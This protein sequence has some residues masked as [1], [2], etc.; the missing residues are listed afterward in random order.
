MVAA[1]L[2]VL[3][4]ACGHQPWSARITKASIAGDD[5]TVT[6]TFEGERFTDGPVCT[7]VDRTEVTETSAV[8]TVEVFI[9]Y[10]C[11]EPGDPFR[12]TSAEQS[13]HIRLESLLG[14]RRLETPDRQSIA[15]TRP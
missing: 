1:L 10:S 6:V 12:G 9:N 14:E 11:V 2:G 13:T 3:I 15:I 7:E 4:T 5:Q 8:V